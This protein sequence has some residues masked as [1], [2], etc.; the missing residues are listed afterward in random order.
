MR[1][2]TERCTRRIGNLMA[3][4][5]N[6]RIVRLTLKG[7]KGEVGMSLDE[8]IRCL[9]INFLLMGYLICATLVHIAINSSK[10]L[11][12]LEKMNKD[13]VS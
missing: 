7:R 13:K 3:T 11:K 4:V 8:V 10:I 1:A 12:E 9:G 6:F 5:R 2:L